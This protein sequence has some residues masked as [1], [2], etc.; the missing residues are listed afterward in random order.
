[1]TSS[2]PFVS[3]GPVFGFVEVIEVISHDPDDSAAVPL[4]SCEGAR[5]A[6]PR[7]M[8]PEEQE[9]AHAPLV[10][11]TPWDVRHQT[12][13]GWSGGRSVSRS[14]PPPVGRG[15]TRPSTVSSA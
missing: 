12:K 1:M 9:Q 10:P 11:V 6:D 4:E 7:R 13:H 14:W 3:C 5:M 2:R 8:T 15:A